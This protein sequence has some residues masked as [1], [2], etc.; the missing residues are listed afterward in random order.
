MP[1]IAGARGRL[2][3]HAT[4]AGTPQHPD[5]SGTA[6]VRDGQILP[7]GRGELIEDLMATSTSTRHASPW[8]A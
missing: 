5:L 8:T 7:A 3:A 4:V 6:H 1:Q 2:D